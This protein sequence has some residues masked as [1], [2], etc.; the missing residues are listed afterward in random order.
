ML[1]ICLIDRTTLK[2]DLV[3]NIRYRDKPH[4]LNMELQTDDD[5]D[6]AIRMLKYHVG[7]YDKHRLPVISMV[8]YLFETSIVQS[9]FREMSGEEKLLI[10][11]FRILRL[12]KL[13][14]QQFVRDHVVCMYTLLPAMRG[15]NALLL[16]QAIEEMKQRYKEPQLRHHLVRFRT[17]LR[18]SKTLSEQDKHIVEDHL[19][20]KYDSLLDGDPEIQERIAQGKIEALQ[21][22]AL[23]AVKSKFPTLVELAEGQVALIREPDAL[24]RLVILIFNASDETTARWLLTTFVA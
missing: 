14:A 12:W 4:V 3:Y 2:A 8:I 1:F 21:E 7:L 16:L 20:T 9:P 15:A 24:R 18:R 10:F 19:H 13:D 11:H 23:E 17:I 6:M 22:M 5:S